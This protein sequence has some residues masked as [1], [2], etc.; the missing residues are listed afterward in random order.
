MFRR[1]GSKPTIEQAALRCLLPTAAGMI[2]LV[3]TQQPLIGAMVVFA[4]A[5]FNPLR[6]G[7][8]DEAGG[9][10]VVRTR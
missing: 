1:H 7:W 2:A 4:S 6:R 8:H 5:F 10:I 3:V 9:T